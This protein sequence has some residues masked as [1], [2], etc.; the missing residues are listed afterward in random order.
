MNED[1]GR[2]RRAGGRAGNK[3]RAG[4]AAIDQ[5]PWRIPVNPDQPT[6]PV[7]MDGLMAIHRGC[8]RILKEIGIEFLNPEAVEILRKAGCK[9]DGTNIRMDEDFVMEMLKT[10]PESFTITP[11][12]PEREIIIGGR[13]MVFV[14]VSSPPNAWDLERGKR[15]GDFETF[16]EFMK[17]T[18]Y[19]NCIHVAGGYPVE[20]I[21]IHPSVR[22]LDC[23][24]EKLT[25]TDKVVHA[26]SLG[27]ERVEDAVFC[28]RSSYESG[29]C[30]PPPPPGV[31]FSPPGLQGNGFGGGFP[32]ATG[33]Y[34][35]IFSSSSKAIITKDIL[36][37]VIDH[38]IHRFL[39]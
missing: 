20:P 16:K 13:H 33:G 23:L 7:D 30:A 3:Q 4:T 9:V 36:V 27:A 25:L 34:N 31:P 11:R 39:F 12:N 2:R 19:F 8:M 14:N 37:R 6:E 29:D 22:H 10:A 32:G 5:M 35:N 17:L 26:Y 24:Y 18:Q 21:D 38:S 1:A 15:S 28:R